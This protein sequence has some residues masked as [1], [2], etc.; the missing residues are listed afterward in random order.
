[1]L[2]GECSQK[3]LTSGT[4]FLFSQ[5][6]GT[7]KR[8]MASI[9]GACLYTSHG[10]VAF[11][12]VQL[13]S[14]IVPLTLAAASPVYDQETGRWGRQF[15]LVSFGFYLF[16]WGFLLYIFQVSLSIMRSDPFCPALQTYGVPASSAFYVAAMGSFLLG[17]AWEMSFWYN[18]TNTLYLVVWWLAPPVVLVWFGFNVWQEVL[19]S[20]GLGILST[21]IFMTVVWHVLV[22]D[23][24]YLLQQGPWSWCNCIDTWIQSAEQRRKTE[25]LRLWYTTG[26]IKSQIRL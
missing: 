24:P 18:I 16:F 12:V 25:E 14:W 22:H 10:A 7:L 15:V 17:L 9:P 3:T 8:K 1:L 21:V 23:M 5:K 13:V 2:L 26:S 6:K 11:A 4:Y 20:M 19:L